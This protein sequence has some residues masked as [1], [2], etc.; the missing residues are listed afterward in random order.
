LLRVLFSFCFSLILY[1]FQLLML[2]IDN[3]VR[4]KE[5]HPIGT[6]TAAGFMSV[7]LFCGC[8]VGYRHLKLSY[9]T[10]LYFTFISVGIFNITSTIIDYRFDK[11]R[12]RK[13]NAN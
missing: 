7:C 10:F 4:K 6:F 3:S 5:V 12:A 1:F 13:S 11:K 9:E 2:I 8:L